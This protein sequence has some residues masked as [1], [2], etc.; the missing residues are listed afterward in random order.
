MSK[1]IA[2]ILIPVFN[3]NKRPC[4]IY[5]EHFVAYDKAPDTAEHKLLQLKQ[6][7]LRE[8]LKKVQSSGQSDEAY[9]EA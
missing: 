2:R 8:V 1:Q 4:G 3:G 9:G 6:S 5:T 7:C